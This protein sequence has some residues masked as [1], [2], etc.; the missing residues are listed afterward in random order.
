MKTKKY[1]QILVIICALTLVSGFASNKEPLGNISNI[2]VTPGQ[3]NTRI[4]LESNSP[5]TLVGSSYAPDRPA[6]IFVDFD[7]VSTNVTPKIATHTTPLIQDIKIQRIDAD[8]FRL[9]VDLKERVPYQIKTEDN[10]TIIELNQIQKTPGKYAFDPD[11][12]S[13]LEKASGQVGYLTNI[14]VA[15]RKDRVDVRATL[16]HEAISNVFVLDKPLRLVVD[17]YN[18]YFSSSQ[19]VHAINQLGVKKVRA[20]QFQISNPHTITR[21]VFDLTEPTFYSMDTANNNLTISFYKERLS[22][23]APAETKPSPPV[24][25]KSEPKKEVN[26][27]VEKKSPPTPV[28]TEEKIE[29]PKTLRP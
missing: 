5:L 29:M 18:T 24:V 23:V 22:H 6:T 14:S 25:E 28:I 9:H 10:N 12:K 7:N 13:K 15:D 8:K 17:L 11:V 3:P 4:I 20:A 21:M 19:S 27:P 1:L 16:S 26:P 2:S